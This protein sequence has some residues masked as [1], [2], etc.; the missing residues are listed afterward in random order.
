MKKQP[1]AGATKPADKNK[2]KLTPAEQVK[3]DE[4]LRIKALKKAEEDKMYGI[5]L[6]AEGL[7]FLLTQHFLQKVWE[8]DNPKQEANE[9]LT[10]QLERIQIL[11]KTRPCEIKAISNQIIYDLIFLKKDLEASWGKIY[12]LSNLLFHN[13]INNDKRFEVSLPLVKEK[14]PNA[15]EEPQQPIEEEEEKAPENPLLSLPLEEGEELE[16]FRD[17]QNTE[18][19]L[20]GK[21]YESDLFDFK[22]NL[23]KLAKKYPDLFTSKSE[24]ASLV[25]HSMISFFANYNLFRYHSIL[26]PTEETIYLQA[27]VDVPTVLPPLKEA[28]MIAREEEPKVEEPRTDE[29]EVSRKEQEEKENKEKERLEEERRAKEAEWLGLDDRTIQIIQ[30]RLEKT[31]DQMIKKI[32][33]KKDEYNEK[34]AA[35]KITLKKK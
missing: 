11:H 35:N 7:P 29:D 18:E 21:S 2:K 1:A 17:K 14:E 20:A 8:S 9:Y 32:E 13:F 19:F 23:A 34:L 30:E 27:T 25:S 33:A 12:V 26:R 31:R 3:L 24:I 10:K 5:R 28:E 16:D 6:G 15:S 4:E 22:S